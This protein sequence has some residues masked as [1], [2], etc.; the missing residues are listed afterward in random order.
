[1]SATTRDKML[2][3]TTRL[4]RVQGFNGT[5]L[6]QI[7]KESGTP[8]GSL[9]YHFPGGKEQLA[10]EAIQAAGQ[11]MMDRM[12]QA[13]DTST[14][15][16]QALEIILK[17]SARELEESDYQ[18]GCPIALVALEVAGTENP[19]RDACQQAFVLAHELLVRNL[20]AAG[21]PQEHAANLAE[22]MVTTYEGA[23]LLARAQR[24]SKPLTNLLHTLPLL[25]PDP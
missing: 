10:A 7:I 25:V 18:C 14:T 2:E 11:M 8:K 16:R 15:P 24:S 17:V 1:M 23:L 3:T 6:N 12:Q 20:T 5:G 4:L 13:F 9:Y 22:L 21:Y 19:V